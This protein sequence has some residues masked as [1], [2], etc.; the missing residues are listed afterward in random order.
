MGYLLQ[1]VTI[2]RE[3]G[4]THQDL[5]LKNGRLLFDTDALAAGSL[6]PVSGRDLHLFP[7][8]TDV[9]VHLREPGFSYKETIATG[10]R[11]AARG[12]FS[13]VLTMPNLKPV[14][15]SLTHLQE[16]TDLINRDALI[17]VLPLGAITTGQQGVELA[18]LKALAPL[19]A[20]FSDDGR[21]VQ[22][23]RMMQ[24]AMV[25]SAALNK[26]IVAHC[27][28]ESLL[29]GGYIHEGEYAGLHNHK[30][31]SSRSEWAQ[32]Q[33]D[34]EL[35]EETG[36]RYHVCHV[37]TKESV[38]LIRDAKA[39]GLD[40]TC[41]TAP[42]YLVL[43]DMDL[44][45]DG[46]FKMNPP[47]R[48]AEDRDALIEGLIDGT[49]DMIATDHAPHSAQEKARGLA[50]SMNGVVGLETAFPVLYTHLVK[51]GILTLQRLLDAMTTR[52]NV[53]FDIQIQDD[54]TLFDLGVQERIDPAGFLSM[55]KA[56]PFS[57]MKVS[58][59][60]LLTIANGELAYLHPSI[61]QKE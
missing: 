12:G 34:L 20:G 35:V 1:K 49:V 13:T 4:T 27:E 26:I 5:V 42:H 38:R 29:N 32:V 9:H 58:G 3:G 37:S 41:E 50:G 18:D 40:V 56:S 52:P 46:R 59:R 19:V 54:W 17:R 14:P 23:K 48:G 36:C 31:I 43:T 22:A 45:E 24:E 11:A 39:R 33:R 47:I 53:R 6:T 21:G 44:Q 55:G 8:F 57:G 30:G 10:T 51:P 25:R 28:D 61:A 2:H 16:Q 60:C 15:D 7:G